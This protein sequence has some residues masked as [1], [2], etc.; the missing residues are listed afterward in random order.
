MQ[1]KGQGNRNAVLQWTVVLVVGVIVVGVVLGLKL[2]P[3]LNAGQDVLDGA[4]PAFTAERVAADRAGINITSQVVDM[5]DPIVNE[6]G[7]AA[8]EVPKVVAYV[9]KARNVTD[10]QALAALDKEFPRTTALLKSL[11]L[12]EV[13]AEIPKLVAF[14]STSLK[15]P[16]DQVSAALATNFPAINAAVTNLPTV[17]NGWEQIADIDGLTR[18][19]G[20]PVTTVPELRDYFSQ[21]VIPAV[22]TQQ[23]NFRSLDGTSKVN[24]ISPLLLVVGLV[25]IALAAVMILRN[26]R[27]GVGGFEALG[28]A[29]IVPVVG[30]VVV[31]L[32]LGLKLIP[33]TTDGQDLLDGLEPAMTA[34]RVA[35]DR[36]GIT[37][38]E[39]IVNTADPI[40]TNEGGAAA[41]VP[42]LVA[43]VAEGT[44]LSP[45]EVL[46]A[47]TK[48]FPRTTALLRPPVVR[49]C[50]GAAG[51][52][53]GHPARAGR[54]AAHRAGSHGPAAGGRGLA[55]GTG[56]RRDDPFRRE[57][58]RDRPERARLL[59]RGR[60]PGSGEPAGELRRA[61]RDLQDRLHRS[62]GA[63]GRAD[64]DRVRAVHGLRRAPG[65]AG[66]CS[67]GGVGGHQHLRR[68]VAARRG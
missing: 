48:N 52:H 18:F 56:G 7:G 67:P 29:V 39:A 31:A 53:Q 62:A 4:R 15:L 58:D 35:G 23:G 41:E 3:R 9:A 12:S 59:Q 19:D 20:T 64:R 10:A 22:E 25:V 37:M 61:E 16:A 49:G 68:V 47:L 46:A 13:S 17:T 11:P 34:E 1:H 57:P 51:G 27:G 21:D 50:E 40:M 33:R 63:A 36:A 60:D 2:I 26:R 14:L 30:V 44:G 38:V 54:R 28:T 24:W 55:R 43:F 32:V 5:A 66:N 8:G 45:D 6:Q 42:K 65:P